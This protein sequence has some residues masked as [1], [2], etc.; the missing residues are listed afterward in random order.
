VRPLGLPIAAG[1]EFDL[2]HTDDKA[3]Y[4]GASHQACKSRG[5]LKGSG[6]AGVA[7][8][9]RILVPRFARRSIQTLSAPKFVTL[10][11]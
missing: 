1:A 7:G 6:A 5:A 10:S 4:L 11:D 9:V 2:D 8:V 3:G